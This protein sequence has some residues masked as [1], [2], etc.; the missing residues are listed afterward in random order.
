GVDDDRNGFVDDI[1]GWDFTGGEDNDPYD[2]LGHGTLV[3][4]VAGAASDNGIGV[5]GVSWGA[6]ILPLKVFPDS[7]FPSCND[8]TSSNIIEAINYAVLVATST[9]HRNY[10]GRLV[11]NM[12]L[13]GSV[14]SAAEQSA[15]DWA[16]ANNI[17][18]VAA[19]GNSKN[20]DPVYPSDYAGVIGVG[21]TD[22]TDSLA[23]FS[24]FGSGTDLVAPGVAIYGAK[25]GGGYGVQDG[26]SFSSPQAAAAVALVFSAKPSATISEVDDILF[27][28]VDDLGAAGKDDVYGYGRLNLFKLMRMAR[29]GNVSDYDGAKESIAIP[30]PFKVSAL[31]RVTFSVPDTIVGQEPRVEIYDVSGMFIRELEGFS[32]DG[33]NQYG[34]KVATGI[35]LFEV[36]TS[37]GKARGRVIV[38]ASD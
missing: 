3:S 8:A 1:R 14:Y 19:K 33:T 31:S 18:V 37:K 22:N 30:N 26:T 27:A 17:P 2:C 12:S 6:K 4:S 32:W 9:A 13:G 11:I 35:Y 28:G 21:A 38:D 15:V 34:A 23:E 7:G 20:S 10:T 16:L 36:S 24:N 5:S 25:L 29:F